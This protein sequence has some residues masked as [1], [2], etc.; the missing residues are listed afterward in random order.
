MAAMARA[1]RIISLFSGAGGMDFGFEAAGFRTMV[2]VEADAD[3]CAT[4]RANAARKDLSVIHRSIFDVPSSEM[5][6]RAAA[7]PGEVDLVIGGPPCQ[8]FSKSGF[9]AR[10]DTPRLT[11]PRAQ[12]LSAY[13]RVVEETRPKALVLENV[14][15][16]AFDG[17]GEGLALLTQRLREINRKCGTNYVPCWQVLSAASY[18][19]PQMRERFF[20]VAQRD[21]KPFRFPTPTHGPSNEPVLLGRPLERYRTTWDALGDVVPDSDEE[22]GPRGKWGDLLASIP[23]GE[24]YLWHTDRGGGSSAVAT[25]TRCGGKPATSPAARAASRALA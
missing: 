24:N 20:L 17:K 11:D 1:P 10:G 9:W 15:G 7:E 14:G 3:C 5:L 25:L 6:E 4:L 13:M 2:T 12:T 8:P 23:E 16:L 19:V 18:G 22:L 21:G